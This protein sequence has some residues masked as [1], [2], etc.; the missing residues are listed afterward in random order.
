MEMQWKELADIIREDII[1][2]GWKEEIQSFSQTYCNTDLD[3]SLLLLETYG[4][5][6][7][8]D[9]RYRKTVDAVYKN[10]MHNG[11]MFRYNNQDDFG[12][13]TSAFTICTFWMVRALFIT[14]KRQEAQQLFDELIGYS[15]HLGLCSEDLDFETKNQLG[16][17]PQAYSHLALINTALL[18]TDELELSRFIK[19]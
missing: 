19:P 17:F 8:D 13:P 18:F 6:Q 1:E 4:F 11:L 15:N 7:A 16:N 5:V 3:A 10:L 2:N 14:G 9:I 12:T